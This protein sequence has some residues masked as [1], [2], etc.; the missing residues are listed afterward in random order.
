VTARDEGH[1]L[2]DLA[3]EVMGDKAREVGMR[4]RRQNF[5]MFP[6]LRTYMRMI[7]LRLTMAGNQNRYG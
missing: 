3:E 7:T 6:S 1:E 4:S 2:R 5:T